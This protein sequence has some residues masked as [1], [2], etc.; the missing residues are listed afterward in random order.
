MKKLASLLTLM[1]ATGV[2][3]AANA[4]DQEVT[5]APIVRACVDKEGKLLSADIFQSS[6]FPELDA[7]ALKIARATKFNPGTEGN[8]P[9]KR[10]CIKFRVK[11]VIRDGEAVPAES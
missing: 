9:L 7:A 6:N 3:V 8:K 2:I 4:A 10:S 11:F 1:F 5:A